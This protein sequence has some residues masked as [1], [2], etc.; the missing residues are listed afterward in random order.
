MLSQPAAAATRQVS[1]AVVMNPM[2]TLYFPEMISQFET[3]SFYLPTD[4]L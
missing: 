1:H 2:T 3:P 4:Q